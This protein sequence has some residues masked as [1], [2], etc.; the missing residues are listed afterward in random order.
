MDVV[1]QVEG[2][3]SPPPGGSQI[4]GSALERRHQRL[5]QL[6]G[7]KTWKS[8]VRY[9]ALC[10]VPVRSLQAQADGHAVANRASA[11]H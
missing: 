1:V 3:P 5:N 10:N 4:A 2:A 7:M 8:S 11:L 9:A 6:F